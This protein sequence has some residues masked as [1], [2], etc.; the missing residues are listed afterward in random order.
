MTERN[1]VDEN[2]PDREITSH[3]LL[4]HQVILYSRRGLNQRS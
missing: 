3:I 4:I 1:N 2:I